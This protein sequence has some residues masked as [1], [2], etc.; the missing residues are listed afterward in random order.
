MIKPCLSWTTLDL[1]SQGRKEEA[2]KVFLHINKIK[3]MGIKMALTLNR[4]KNLHHIVATNKLMLL[5]EMNATG[6]FEDRVSGRNVIEVDF[7]D[8]FR[9][10]GIIDYIQDDWFCDWKSGKTPVAKFNK[11]QFFIY[12][13]LLKMC[14]IDVK[15][16]KAVKIKQEKYT[17]RIYADAN[18]MTTIIFDDKKLADAEN[19]IET[20]GNEFYEDI[21]KYL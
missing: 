14:G 20:Y 5:P 16:A 15:Y 1:W 21:S 19:F 4:G 8:R 9:F 12:A 6:I 17:G 13:L 3:D 10:K 7:N 18:D 11:M 2:I